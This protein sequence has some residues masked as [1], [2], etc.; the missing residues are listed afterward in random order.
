MLDFP[1]KS[2]IAQRTEI[3]IP[4]CHGSHLHN[5]RNDQAPTP[6]R[7]R[8]TLVTTHFRPADLDNA[9][10]FAE[11]G[12]HRRIGIYFSASSL[13]W[14][15][16]FVRLKYYRGRRCSRRE[17]NRRRNDYSTLQRLFNCENS[18]FYTEND[19]AIYSVPTRGNVYK[20]CC[21]FHCTLRNRKTRSM[22]ES[23][24]H[25]PDE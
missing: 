24:Y 2:R 5:V 21:G 9:L 15:L 1:S 18:R 25:A 12:D 19:G 8:G 22:F 6:S 23:F 11:V 17:I 20:V 13:S 4:N 14:I 7:H 3:K 16:F 10:M